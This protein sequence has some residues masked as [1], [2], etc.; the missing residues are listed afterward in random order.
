M[1]KPIAFIVGRLPAFS[2]VAARLPTFFFIAL[3][4]L[5]AYAAGRSVPPSARSDE[6]AATNGEHAGHDDTGSQAADVE[7]VCPMHPQIRQDEPGTCPICFMDLVPV[8]LGGGGSDNGV[9]LTMSDSAVRLSHVRTG[10]VERVPLARELDVFGRVATTDDGAANITAWTGGRIERLYVQTIGD[11]VRR[12]QRLARI[13]SP[14]LVVAQETLVHA[15]G[16]LREATEAGST[17]RMQAAT[18]AEHAAKTELRLL[19]ISDSQ[20]EEL[21][22]DGTADETVLIYAPAGGTVMRRFANEGD[23]VQRG[24]AIL[25]LADLDE[26]WVQLEVYE[27]D[28]RYIDIGTHVDL[29]I[30][31]AAAG[32]L[33][34]T[35]A[36]I[37]PVVDPARRVARARVVLDNDDGTLR[38]DMFVEATIATP[39][40][41][42]RGRPPVSV[43]ASSVLW[44][45][46]RSVVYVYDAMENP[47][48]YMPVEVEI[49]DR[50][51]E[52]QV[53]DAGVF[54]GETVVVEGAFRLDASLQIRG[55][56]SMMNPDADQ[57]TGGGHDH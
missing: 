37:D 34:G 40:T 25:E 53:I 17:S 3:F 23:H 31:G 55:G 20:I 9:S 14:E 49:G 12:G 47:P 57:N 10:P 33:S 22:A 43:P 45:G 52:R 6:D 42:D 41:D 4:S 11:T 38:P 46:T 35:I 27:R 2:S 29:R 51:G 19:G 1:I 54:P 30:P 50:I 24:S 8:Q 26:V 39:V 32:E 18:A 56:A 28:L 44:T 5:L 13:Y 7:Y 15:R 48:V 16:I 36:F 21:V